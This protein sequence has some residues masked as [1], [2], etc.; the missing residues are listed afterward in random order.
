MDGETSAHLGEFWCLILKYLEANLLEIELR[1]R[2]EGS[3][4]HGTTYVLL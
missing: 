3:L 2:P 1:L 4:S